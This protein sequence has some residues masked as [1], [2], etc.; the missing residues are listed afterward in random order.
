MK[1][2]K[3]WTSYSHYHESADHQRQRK[4]LRSSREK[5]ILPKMKDKPMDDRIH[6]KISPMN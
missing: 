6:W 1:N 5:D 3:E 2:K 4:H